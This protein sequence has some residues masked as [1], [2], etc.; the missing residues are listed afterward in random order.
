MIC[1]RVIRLF[2]NNKQIKVIKI[3]RQLKQDLDLDRE[4]S[5]KIYKEI[6]VRINDKDSILIY[7]E[8]KNI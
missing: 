2:N 3:Y 6:I 7:M 4:I 5:I 8:S 1:K